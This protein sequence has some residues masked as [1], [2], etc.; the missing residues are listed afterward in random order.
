MIKED[1]ED[2][3]AEAV[4]RLSGGAQPKR[5]LEEYATRLELHHAFF[6]VT[7]AQILFK[8]DK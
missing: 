1:F 5:L 8:K 7:Q 6:I 4:K 2:Q 3:I